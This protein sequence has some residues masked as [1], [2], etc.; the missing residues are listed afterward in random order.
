M[1]T[2][3]KWSFIIHLLIKSLFSSSINQTS[4]VRL[5]KHTRQW[6]YLKNGVIYLI[7]R[8]HLA[9]K[10]WS[11]TVSAEKLLTLR[12]LLFS[13]VFRITQTWVKHWQLTDMR[14]GKETFYLSIS[15]HTSSWAEGHRGLLEMMP[16]VWGRR[17]ADTQGKS[18][19]HHGATHRQEKA[20]TLLFTPTDN[21][22][23]LIDS[24]CM[25]LECGGEDGETRREP[26][27]GEHANS[28]Q[29]GP[30]PSYFMF[31]T[32][33]YTVPAALFRTWILLVLLLVVLKR[34]KKSAFWWFKQPG[35]HMHAD[36]TSILSCRRN[37]GLAYRLYSLVQLKTRKVISKHASRAVRAGTQ[38]RVNANQV[39]R[40]KRERV[41]AASG[42]DAAE[43]WNKGCG[44]MRGT[45]VQVSC[46]QA[47]GNSCWQQTHGWQFKSEGP[48]MYRAVWRLTHKG[49]V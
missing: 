24:T 38:D 23:I 2:S 7:R 9:C 20:F 39:R 34:K 36:L 1:R 4:H 27:Q 18:P 11:L 33:C 43:Y 29:K 37:S 35:I 3:L 15:I 22:E 26:T 8:R 47:R 31:D 25:S 48:E 32:F 41:A 19:V 21:L 40:R 13:S 30:W 49:P 10:G 28:T 42:S 45:E 46:R 5:P 6:C 44:L 14:T 16:A 17:Q 12:K